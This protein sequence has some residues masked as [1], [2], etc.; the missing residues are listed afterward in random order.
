MPPMPE[1]LTDLAHNAVQQVVDS[2]PAKWRQAELR[3]L[4][5]VVPPG[6]NGRDGALDDAADEVELEIRIFNPVDPTR[7]MIQAEQQ[8]IDT[9][10]ELYIA[11]YRS[12]DRW[13]MFSAVMDL[14]RHDNW[15]VETCFQLEKDAGAAGQSELSTRF[16]DATPQPGPEMS[17]P[18][19]EL[20]ARHAAL[21]LEKHLVF[22]SLF[23]EESDWEFDAATGRLL[24]GG[25]QFEVQ[26]L[27][28]FS[29]ST[30]QWRWSWDCHDELPGTTLQAAVRVRDVGAKLGIPEFTDPVLNAD[31][32]DP[33]T[34]AMTACGVCGAGFW[35]ECEHD[36]ESVFVL[37]NAAAVTARLSHQPADIV[38]VLHRLVASFD[39]RHLLCLQSYLVE[40]GF[41]LAY[42]NDRLT[43]ESADGRKMTAEFQHGRLRDITVQNASRGRT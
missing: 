29:E 43:A 35:L 19:E 33:E 27:G 30:N 37:G 40:K 16:L 11:H 2:L 34:L 18:L 4:A 24:L 42:D 9:L 15:N 36:G 32:A 22:D 14:D 38:A 21:S 7:L 23:H 26:V 28:V 41:R 13:N 25:A 6:G 1:N 3:V 20:F 12:G 17:Q 8:V 10:A 31:A 5:E 39:V